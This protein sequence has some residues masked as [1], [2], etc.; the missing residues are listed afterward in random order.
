MYDYNAGVKDRKSCHV[1]NGKSYDQEAS[2]QLAWAPLLSEFKVTYIVDFSCGSV[3]KNLPANAGD[4]G[5]VPGSGR[6][7]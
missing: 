2:S 7:P 4:T 1:L 6:C 3:V 5:L